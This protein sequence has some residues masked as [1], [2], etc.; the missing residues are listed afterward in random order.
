MC[1]RSTQ[2][3]LFR[4]IIAKKKRQLETLKEFIDRGL[5]IHFLR[6]T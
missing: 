5:I 1:K 3:C 4:N 6:K 2:G